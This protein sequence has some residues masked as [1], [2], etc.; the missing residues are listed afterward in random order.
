MYAV[1]L[2]LFLPDLLA[3]HPGFLVL[4]QLNLQSLILPLL[5][6]FHLDCVLLGGQDQLFYPDTEIFLVFE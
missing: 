6:L 2:P 5:L 4:P 3:R 1:F